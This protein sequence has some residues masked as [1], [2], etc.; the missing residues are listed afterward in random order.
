[1]EGGQQAAAEVRSEFEELRI[2]GGL[3]L[4]EQAAEAADGDL[5]VLDVDV[6]IEGEVL[7]DVLLGFGCLLIETHQ[8]H[9]VEAVDLAHVQGDAI[10]VVG[11]FGERHQCIVAPGIG[12]IA[13]P[14]V[15]IFGADA[16][17]HCLAV[18]GRAESGGGLGD[19]RDAY[20]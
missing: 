13:L 12:V 4:A 8:Q 10:P 19:G 17:C 14:G 18:G 7:V 5:E 15:E 16:G 1:M 9:G 11:L 3:V 6:L 20:R 2:V